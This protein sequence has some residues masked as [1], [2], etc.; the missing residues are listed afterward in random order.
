MADKEIGSILKGIIPVA[1]YVFY[2]R[3]VYSRAA[4]PALVM[5]KA[6]GLGKA[7]EKVE[8]L[9]E[10]LERARKMAAPEDL[11]VVCGSLFTVGEALAYLKPD[12]YSPDELTD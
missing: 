12:I 1:D 3:P 6:K 8:L 4:S 2:T 7:G 11:I 5:E 9:T 10:A